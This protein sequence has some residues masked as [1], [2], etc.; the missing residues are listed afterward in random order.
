ML[1]RRFPRRS[2]PVQCQPPMTSQRHHNQYQ[3]GAACFWTSSV[4]E[5]VP[6]LASREVGLRLLGIGEH[7]RARFGVKL[8]GHVITPNHSH[9]LDWSEDWE[10]SSARWYSDGR[11]ALVLDQVDGS[12]V[13]FG[14]KT[15]AEVC[16]RPNWTS[17]ASSECTDRAFMRPSCGNS[18][19]ARVYNWGWIRRSRRIPTSDDSTNDDRGGAQRR[20]RSGGLTSTFSGHTMWP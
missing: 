8:E 5:F 15:S 17:S 1:R 2:R 16:E 3:D 11:V 18:C 7:Y 10:F 19:P 6:V 20:G 12:E 4:V 9:L 13:R 14:A